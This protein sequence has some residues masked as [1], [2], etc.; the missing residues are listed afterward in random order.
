HFP[1]EAHLYVLRSVEAHARIASI[2]VEAAKAA[3]GVLAVLTG[4]DVLAEGIGTLPNMIRR[5]RRPGEPMFEPPYPALCHD[6]VRHVGDGVAAVVAET[7]A[8]A[9]DAAELIVVDYESLPAVTA[10]AAAA[11]EGAPAVWP[12]APDNIC[13]VFPLG[14]AAAVEAAFAKAAHVVALDYEISRVSTNSMEARGAIGLYDA[15]DGRYTIYTASQTPHALRANIARVL[16]VGPERVRLISPDVGGGFGLKASIFPEHV[17]VLLAAKRL[18]RPVRWICDRSE[19]FISDHHARD[20]VTHAELALDADGRFLGLRVRTIANLGAYLSSVAVQAPTG[21]LGSLAGVYTTPAIHAEVTGVFSNTNPTSPYRGAG[22]PEAI[23]VLERLIDVAAAETGID[24]IELRRRNII[25]ADAMPYKTGLVFTYDSGE[26]EKNMDEAMRMADWA[27]FEARRAEAA[28]RGKLRGIGLANAI[29]IAGGPPQKPLEE[30]AEIRFAPDGRATLFVGTASQGQGHETMFRQIVFEALGLDP[31]EVTVVSGDTDQ[32]FD[33][34]GTIGSRSMMSGGGALRQ[35][36]DKIIAKGK[37]IAAHLLEAAEVDIEFASGAFTVAGTDRRVTL[38]E[39]AKAAHDPARLPPGVEPG[40][41]ERAVFFPEAPTYP[42]GCHVC[43][44]EIDP[45]TGVVRFI[46]YWVVDDVGRVLNPLLMKG[47]IQGG[48][49]QGIGQALGEIIRYDPETGQM[50]SGSFMDYT[51]PRADDVPPFEI[52]S[53]EVPTT[54]NPLGVKGAGEAGTVGAL[55][56]VMNAVND[57][58]RPLGIRHFE[59][60]ATPMRV[61][62]AI[63]DAKR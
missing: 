43:E 34:R 11:A 51:M 16:G 61:W 46:G 44:V 31:E 55:A 58:L 23:Y 28:K 8:A 54:T 48:V 37:H 38:V 6:V 5:E 9:R 50:L 33:G 40:L 19:G 42:N 1:D 18:G 17:L 56:A 45:E 63:R 27:G 12:E 15:A 59:M 62:Q 10:T 52:A 20:N 30:A 24:R 35:A 25:P 32:V 53:N 4:A 7:P 36:A 57:A 13:F 22:R 3:P 60:P 2:D 39:I 29:E 41:D 49:V 21:N 26:F 47:Q 14:D